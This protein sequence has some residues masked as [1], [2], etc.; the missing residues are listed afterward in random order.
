M[1][2]VANCGEQVYR[3]L[4]SA[5]PEPPRDARI[6]VVNQSPLNAVG[7]TQ[8]VKL[9]YGRDDVEAVAL[10]LAPQLE[11]VSRDRVYRTGP[12]SVRV[13]RED[14]V[15]FKSFVERFLLFSKPVA[16]L[17]RSAGR[18]GLTLPAPP[19]SFDG[20]TELE[21][22]LPHDLDDER[23]LLFRWENGHVRTLGDLIWFADWP[24]LV[25]CRFEN[26]PGDLAGR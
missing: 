5:V 12:A 21:F 22:G 10:A 7:F 25:R 14:G 3:D 13:V 17:P 20:L 9:R 18:V 8:G 19:T 6:F 23:V 15:F 24:R 4:L 1:W 2:R 26:D 16:E 11:G